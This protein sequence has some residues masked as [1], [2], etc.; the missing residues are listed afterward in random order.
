MSGSHI[1]LEGRTLNHKAG[2]IAGHSTNEGTE[3][4]VVPFIMH[5]IR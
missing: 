5:S 1:S 4:E 2:N 3:E